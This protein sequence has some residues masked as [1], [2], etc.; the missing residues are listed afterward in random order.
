MS[1]AVGSIIKQTACH[2]S[3]SK[4]KN[5]AQATSCHVDISQ[6]LSLGQTSSIGHLLLWGHSA[7]AALQGAKRGQ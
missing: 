3:V 6:R 1:E 2:T 7:H 5:E 4:G